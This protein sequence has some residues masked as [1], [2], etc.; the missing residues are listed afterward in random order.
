VRRCALVALIAIVAAACSSSAKPKA[1]PA[2]T[3]GQTTTT[4]E[5]KTASDK[6]TAR[7][8]ALRL[9]DFPASWTA[10]PH[11]DS[12]DKSGIGKQFG[13][14]VGLPPDTLIPHA[15]NV[16]S[17]DFRTGTGLKEQEV[18]NSVGIAS[19]E[20]VSKAF[21]VLGSD[22]LP[23]CFQ[24]AI[25]SSLKTQAGL[26]NAAVGKA[27]VEPLSVGDFGDKTLAY[28]VA[29][30]VTVQGIT[31]GVYVDFV[32]V[33]VGK[34]GIFLSTQTLSQPFDNGLRTHLINAVVDRAKAAA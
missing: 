17:P 29:V 10:T 12:A 25:D 4:T 15:E 21:E 31:V 23:Q 2:T 14:C 18:Q 30:D 16:D 27:K 7:V 26:A 13:E 32:F 19:V 1:S 8:I 22:K 20:D 28:R 5:T 33:Q 6:A 9:S 34:I 3:A 11:P 24:D